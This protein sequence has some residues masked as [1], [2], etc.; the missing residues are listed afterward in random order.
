MQIEIF[1]N[2]T[3]ALYGIVAYNW[4]AFSF[5]KD[6]F[7]NTRKKFSFN[8]YIKNRWDNWVW[9]LLCVPIIVVYGDQLFYYLMEYFEKDWEFLDVV[10]LFAGALAELLYLIFK[11]MKNISKAI[12]SINKQ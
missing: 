11:K 8:V 3:W 1:N 6:G 5:T 10:Y 4:L 9:S 2:W 7:D 12:K